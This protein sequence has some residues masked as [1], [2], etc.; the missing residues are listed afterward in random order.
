MNP[1]APGYVADHRFGRVGRIPTPTPFSVG[2]INSYLLL[3][4]EP[5]RGVTLIDTGVR[6]PEAFEAMARGLKEYGYGF[7]QIEQILVTHAHPDHFGQARRLVELSGARVYASE[8]EGARME[9]GWSPRAWFRGVAQ[10]WFRRFGTPEELLASD[11]KAADPAPSVLEAVDV[12]GI[13]APGDEIAAGDLRLRV[14]PT[15]GHTEGHIVFYEPDLRLLF[16]GDHL[17]TNISPVPLLHIPSEGEPR[18][19]SLVLFMESLARVEAMDCELVFPSHG[20]V[21]RDH[22]KLIDGYRLHHRRRALQI[23]RYLAGGPRTPYEVGA[24]IFK[25]FVRTDL[26]L[27]MSEVMGHLDVLELDGHV[28]IE[29]EAGVMRARWIHDQAPPPLDPAK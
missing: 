15:P 23:A 11:K 10:D 2:D 8:I 6:T 24:R 19:K 27:V 9:A 25:H 3:P 13:L 7:D 12:D 5:G 29:E 22:H 14:V 20:D 4:S 26:F 17:L 28:A 21:I 16:S 1:P 18:Q